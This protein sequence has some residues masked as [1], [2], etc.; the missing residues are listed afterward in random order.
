MLNLQ[1]PNINN[2]IIYLASPSP[3]KTN[4]ENTTVFSTR[5]RIYPLCPISKA[6]PFSDLNGFNNVS[7]L[8]TWTV[9][10]ESGCV[11]AKEIIYFRISLQLFY[12]RSCSCPTKWS[13]FVSLFSVSM[14]PLQFQTSRECKHL[15]STRKKGLSHAAPGDGPSQEGHGSARWGWPKIQHIWGSACHTPKIKVIKVIFDKCSLKSVHT[16]NFVL[17]WL[18]WLPPKPTIK[19]HPRGCGTSWMMYRSQGLQPRA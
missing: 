9:G 10:K 19:C 14:F 3:K 6:L 11:W 8:W 5:R 4:Q 16:E 18:F 12:P 2:I 7:S 13:Y 15:W 17:T 1:C